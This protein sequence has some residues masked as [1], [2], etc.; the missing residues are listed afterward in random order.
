MLE[1]FRTRP[2]LATG[3]YDEP[4]EIQKFINGFRTAFLALYGSS[5]GVFEEI[6][7]KRGW[8]P[9]AIGWIPSMREANLSNAEI[10]RELFTIEIESYKQL[11]NLQ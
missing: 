6:G 4:E 9:S 10:V 5:T 7:I 2:D 8:K 11:F 3:A 1:I